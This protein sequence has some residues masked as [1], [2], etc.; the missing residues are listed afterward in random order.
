[1]R[2]NNLL[3]GLIGLLMLG[4]IGVGVMALRANPGA[5]SQIGDSM[6][7]SAQEAASS[8]VGASSGAAPQAQAPASSG[9]YTM[10]QV[11]THNDAS[12]CWSA[13]GGGV[14]DL[15]AWINQHPGGRAAILSLC[16]TDGT[17]AFEAQHG[18]ERR[19][20]AELASLKI[21]SLVQ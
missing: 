5:V 15:T 10:A 9:G 14:Y 21:G 7:D 12:S 16:G 17:S 19:P 1:M 6:A 2:T 4:I 3:F 8:I 13:I 20:E 18:G 11:A